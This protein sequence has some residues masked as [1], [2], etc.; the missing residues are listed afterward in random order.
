MG[1][2]PC[3]MGGVFVLEVWGIGDGV[4]LGLVVWVIIRGIWLHVLGYLA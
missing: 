3:C 4:V 2:S 1:E